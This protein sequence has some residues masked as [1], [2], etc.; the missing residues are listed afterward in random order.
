[1]CTTGSFITVAEILLNHKWE[2]AFTLDMESW[3]FRDNM[4]PSDVLRIEVILE[5]VITTVSCGGE[6]E[7]F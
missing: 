3:S 5:K 1:M 4:Q 6:I 7:D 2:N